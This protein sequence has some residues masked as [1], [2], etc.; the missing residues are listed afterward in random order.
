MAGCPY[1]RK[2]GGGKGKK[3][4]K[5]TIKK[6]V[7]AKS[8]IKKKK[9]LYKRRSA[10]MSKR[11]STRMSKRRSTRM[12]KRSNRNKKIG[13]VPDEDQIRAL[14]ETLDAR[15]VYSFAIEMNID[16][17]NISHAQERDRRDGVINLI[18]KTIMG[19]GPAPL[20]DYL[21]KEGKLTLSNF[22]KYEKAEAAAAAERRREN[23]LAEEEGRGVPAPVLPRAYTKRWGV[24]GSAKDWFGGGV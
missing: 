19:R 18:V 22:I 13:G 3:V 12:S 5:S 21:N 11:R 20:T 10:R 9:S 23:M 17:H 6:P 2:R 16:R 7:K 24:P 14:L 8:T 4:K 15:E 1:T